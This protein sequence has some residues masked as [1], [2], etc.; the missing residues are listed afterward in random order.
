[1]NKNEKIS[2]EVKIL[3]GSFIAILAIA[4]G[5][6]Y[7]T[8]PKKIEQSE[9]NLTPTNLVRDFNHKTGPEN[10]KIKLVEFYDPECEAC[11]AFA[12]HI[13]EI[14][15]LHKNDIQLTVRYALYHGNSELAARASEAAAIQGKFWEYHDLLF[16]KQ[17]EWSH[18]QTPATEYLVRYAKDLSLDVTKF[19]N[20]MNDLKRMETISIDIEDGKKLEVNGTPTIFL[21]GKMLTKLNP[22]S[23]KTMIENELKLKYM[24]N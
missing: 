14:L 4:I 12:P 11:A 13:K 23:F 15:S 22:T 5:I 21:N 10:A 8:Q 9:V 16:I 2:N 7:F 20:D 17:E 19:Q 1:M 6:F 18:K 3:A 24:S